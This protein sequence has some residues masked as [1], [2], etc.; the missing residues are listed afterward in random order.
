LLPQKFE[1]CPEFLKRLR[2]Y[3][4]KEINNRKVYFKNALLPIAA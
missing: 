4:L 3:F 1:N 2:A